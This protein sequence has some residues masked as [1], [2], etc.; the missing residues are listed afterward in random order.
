MAEVEERHI[1]LHRPFSER[2]E[3]L[4]DTRCPL[5]WKG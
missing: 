1:V 2:K 5:P 3:Q 4:T